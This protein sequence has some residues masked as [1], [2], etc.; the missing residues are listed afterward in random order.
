M[1]RHD[2]CCRSTEGVDSF[3]NIGGP[4]S[5][6]DKVIVPSDHTAS[7]TNPFTN[8]WIAFIPRSGRGLL[9]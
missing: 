3:E 9:A 7:T 5:N 8:P 4:E 1:R 2:V 6:Q